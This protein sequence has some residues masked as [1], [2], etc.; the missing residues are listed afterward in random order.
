VKL[1]SDS[2]YQAAIQHPRQAFAD[3]ELQAAVPE[4]VEAGALA[5]LP[6]PRAGNFA[7]VYKLNHGER[8]FAVRCF[9]RPIQSDQAAR[10]AEIIRHLSANRMPCAVDVAFLDRGIQVH[11]DWFPVVKMEWVQ[12]ES[13][14]RHVDKHHVSPRALFNLAAAWVELQ[15][16]LRRMQVAHGDLQHGNVVIAPEGLRLV[17]YDGMFVPAL[18]GRRSHERGH[19][20]YQH[21]DRTP[22]FFDERLDQFS[23][24]VVWASLVA[25]AHEPALWARFQGGDDCLLFRKKDFVERQRSPLF[26]ALLSSPHERVRTVASF[27]LDSLLTRPP[28]EVPPLDGAALAGIPVSTVPV[29][30]RSAAKAA[31][32]SGKAAPALPVPTAALEVSRFMVPAPAAPPP[33]LGA[34][35]L[36]DRQVANGI[37]LAGGLSAVLAV[38]LSPA[39]WVG[40][41]LTGGLGW[42]WARSAFLRQGALKRRGEL[43]ASLVTT[44]RELA[45]AEARIQQLMERRDHREQEVRSRSARVLAGMEALQR[46]RDTSLHQVRAT[47]ASSLTRFVKKRRELEALEDEAR[48]ALEAE[49]RPRVAELEVQLRSFSTAAHALEAALQGLQ[50]GHLTKV[51]QG[52]RLEAASLHGFNVTPKMMTRLRTRGLQSAADVTVERLARISKLSSAQKAILLQWRAGLEATARQTMPKEL[53]EARKMH[54]EMNW[55]TLRSQ[56]EQ[57]LRRLGEERVERSEA[58]AASFVEQRAAVSRE[59]DAAVEALWRSAS[60]LSGGF[61]REREQLALALKSQTAS[62]EVLGLELVAARRQCANLHWRREELE[63]ELALL[64]TLRFSRYLAL[65]LKDS[66]EAT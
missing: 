20:N 44:Q 12:G 52:V 32:P 46:R 38:A 3:P 50:A 54:L 39:W 66:Q 45:E 31:L 48:Q 28:H 60:E 33:G 36:E 51:L 22:D 21:P 56:L 30:P 6:R 24:W 1:P 59:E 64:A 63:R 14:A 5:G 7:T 25:L 62:L 13:L 47:H 2:D 37:L 9:T 57:E 16:D 34:V 58:L 42:G 4:L 35:P 8:A 19:A 49:L 23:A 55:V 29:G 41:G 43:Q 40:L 15:A 53:P 11:G 27:L 65:L 26:Q 61:E 17:D 18:A 10:Y